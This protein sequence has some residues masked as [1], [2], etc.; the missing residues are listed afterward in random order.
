MNDE[1]KAAFLNAQTALLNAEIQGMVA[2]NQHRMACGNSVAYGE[3]A[4]DAAIK[5]YEGIL[6]YNAMITFIKD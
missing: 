2:E 5:R 6:G 1:L 4:F 3:E